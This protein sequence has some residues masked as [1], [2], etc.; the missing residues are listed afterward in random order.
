MGW[1]RCR[2]YTL[3]RRL[4]GNMEA[5]QLDILQGVLLKSLSHIPGD[6]KEGEAEIARLGTET[7]FPYALILIGSDQAR[8]RAVRHLSLIVLRQYVKEH[9]EG[10]LTEACTEDFHRL[11]LQGLGDTVPTLQTAFGMVVAALVN[12][13]DQATSHKIFDTL[14]SYLHSNQETFVVGT[15]KCF[16]YVADT[17]D[18]N[19]LPLLA[20]ALLPPLTHILKNPDTFSPAIRA[21]SASILR[22]CVEVFCYASEGPVASMAREAMPLWVDLFIPQ[23]ELKRCHAYGLEE[24]GVQIEILRIFTLTLKSLLHI[25]GK[26]KGNEIAAKLLQYLMELVAPY[27]AS[28]ILSDDDGEVAALDWG[29]SIYDD[30][31]NRIGVDVAI[32]EVMTSFITILD[33]GSCRAFLKS[34]AV[35]LLLDITVEFMCITDA[36]IFD[37]EARPE[38]YVAHEDELVVGNNFSIRNDAK[39]LIDALAERN[40]RTS[41]LAVLLKR[42]QLSGEAST[43]SSIQWKR[44]EATLAAIDIAFGFDSSD[45]KQMHSIIQQA[46]LH[47]F[48]PA[49]LIGAQCPSYL[50]AQ[51]LC[52]YGT[53]GICF[54]E[55]QREPFTNTLS[56]TLVPHAPM[57]IKL[58]S[59]KAL[60]RI[61]PNLNA[62][63]R[64][65][66]SP[67]GI[68]GICS[69][70]HAMPAET[71]HFMLETLSALLGTMDEQS[72]SS[73][74]TSITPL[75]LKIWS[76]NGNDRLLTSTIVETFEQLAKSCMCLSQMES[77]LMPTL[78]DLLQTQRTVPPFVLGTVVDLLHVVFKSYAPAEVPRPMFCAL[79]PLLIQTT[80][81]NEDGFVLQ[82]CA[83]CFTDLVS[84]NSSQISAFEMEDA[85]H[86]QRQNG[87]DSLLQAMSRLVSFESDGEETLSVG[88]L[89][90]SVL[91]AFAGN[92]SINIE[93]VQSIFRMVATKISSTSNAMIIQ[94]YVVC[95]A[96]LFLMHVPQAM[97][98]M[99]N[100]TIE[101]PQGNATVTANALERIM[102]VWL[103]YQEFFRGSY[104]TKICL[105]ALAKIVLS[106]DARIASLSVKGDL[107]V[108]INEGRMTRSSRCKSEA[109]YQSIPWTVRAFQILARTVDDTSEC[110]DDED[111]WSN[112]DDSSADGEEML[113]SDMIGDDGRGI[114]DDGDEEEGMD[115]GI[116]ESDPFFKVDL[117]TELQQ[118]FGLLASTEAAKFQHYFNHLNPEEQ[119]ILRDSLRK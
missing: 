43:A 88:Y 31:D 86:S 112:E 100:T 71:L 75:L 21:R 99:A 113:L 3:R 9:G 38:N 68:H 30:A 110:A 58:A 64:S 87:V 118:F 39:S 83:Q 54:S 109:V 79:F 78:I 85:S 107:R 97:E 108:D 66:V 98:L 65:I 24:L 60:A 41:T 89:L 23:V 32:A 10:R 51:V 73:V 29:E 59:L 33:R 14:L 8:P 55:K 95:F 2:A 52:S 84:T 70:L 101:V 77:S 34:E 37:W 94:D 116:C 4:G 45:H 119:R 25:I 13:D 82:A 28:Y 102:T 106:N 35:P 63:E 76:E 48:L 80:L 62:R 7:D 12:L 47:A 44:N 103:E 36:Q 111:E 96:R 22:G 93:T 11:T 26:Q 27:T 17:F 117:Q 1:R 40:G 81:F 61:L 91:L 114:Y 92:G 16:S 6:Q 15:V 49:H 67:I 56:K 19:T 5:R 50:C 46:Q 53:V 105:L 74:E 57:P 18:D 115:E 69:L 42:L 90:A 20:P 72:T 104:R